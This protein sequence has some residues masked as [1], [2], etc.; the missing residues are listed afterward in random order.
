MW[1]KNI[2]NTVLKVQ[3]R[4]KF[5]RFFYK[6][7]TLLE[8]LILQSRLFHSDIVGRKNKIEIIVLYELQKYYCYVWFHNS[9]Q[10]RNQIQ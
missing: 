7:E 8:F 10:V 2:K 1:V 6:I 3:A 5:S 9:V 4:T